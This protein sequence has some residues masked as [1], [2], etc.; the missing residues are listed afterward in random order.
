MA[1]YIFLSQDN[2]VRNILYNLKKTLSNRKKDGWKRAKKRYSGM[3]IMIAKTTTIPTL[4][5]HVVL[6]GVIFRQISYIVP[7]ARHLLPVKFFSKYYFKKLCFQL[8]QNVTWT[9][10]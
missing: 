3:Q 6:N 4:Y 5:V 8:Q 2:S 9:D 10:E 7:Y 1:T